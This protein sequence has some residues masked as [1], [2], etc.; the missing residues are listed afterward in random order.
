M[1]FDELHNPYALLLAL[2]VPPY[3]LWLMRPGRTAAV[4]Y[5][6]VRN[7]KRLPRTIRQRCRAGLP[8]LRG[9]ALLALVVVMARPLRQIETD[10]LPSE[11]I[12]ILMLVDRSSS[13]GDPNNK[14]LYQDTLQFRF[15][16]AKQVA[17]DFINGNDDALD[18][19]PND[20][21]GLTTFAGFPE[22]NY[23]FTLFHNSL[24]AGLKRMGPVQPLLTAIGQPTRDTA[25]AAIVRDSR[26]R[27]S[28]RNNPMDGTNL[29]AAVEYGA[30]QLI[31]LGDDLTRPGRGVQQYNLK[32]KVMVL[33]TDG[34]AERDFADAET[35]KKLND[36]AIKVYVIQILSGQQFRERP[37]GTIEV[38]IPESER[39]RDDLFSLFGSSSIAQARAARLEGVVNEAIQRARRLADETGGVH[40]LATSGDQ[41]QQTYARIDEL[42]KSDVG[43]RTVLSRGER[44]RPFLG[45][46]LALLGIESVL[47]L[48][49]LRRAP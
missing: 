23:P 28:Y 30:N 1:S 42:E 43:M 27:R 18:G 46:A 32:S 45:L 5:P 37:D 11:G 49:W 31:S 22:S 9:L 34:L 2:L 36:E 24:V 41:L 19:R 6:S 38:V 20:L 26:G 21:I 25:K 29:Q 3:V 40:F 4:R 48:T 7:L 13:M 12:A 33:L 14:L 10:E 35:V 47:G 16:V 8:I 44:Y 17:I 39:R 15:D